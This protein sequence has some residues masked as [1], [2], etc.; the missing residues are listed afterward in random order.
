MN[1]SREQ[2]SQQSRHQLCIR[3]VKRKVVLSNKLRFIDFDPTSTHWLEEDSREDGTAERN[4]PKNG[5]NI[6]KRECGR[7]CSIVLKP[8]GLKP[9][10]S[11]VQRS[12][13]SYSSIFNDSYPFEESPFSKMAK[14]ARKDMGLEYLGLDKFH[15]PRARREDKGYCRCSGC[16]SSS[17]SPSLM[18]ISNMVNSP[19][20]GSLF[21]RQDALDVTPDQSLRLGI[22]P[23]SP[24]NKMPRCTLSLSTIHLPIR[25][26]SPETD[27]ESMSLSSSSSVGRN[28]EFPYS[29]LSDVGAPYKR[30][31]EKIFTSTPLSKMNLLRNK[32]EK[33]KSS[34]NPVDAAIHSGKITKS[35]S[36]NTSPASTSP[37]EVLE[38]DSS[39][40]ENPP[41]TF[42]SHAA[43]SAIFHLCRQSTDVNFS[44]YIAERSPV[45]LKKLGEGAFSEVFLCI[46]E[47]GKQ[48]IWKV[49]PFGGDLIF[50]GMAQRKSGDILS[51]IRLIRSLSDLRRGEKSMTDCFIEVLNF[52]VVHGPFPKLLLDCW[53]E[54]D[55]EKGSENDCPSMFPSTQ[56]FMI[57]EMEYAGVELENFVFASATQA[58]SV[59]NQVAF[60]LAVAEVALEFEHRDLHWGNIIV[61]K[62]PVEEITFILNEK[63]NILKTRGVI[64]KIVDFSL[65]RAT[66]EGDIYF[67]DLADIPEIF[68]STGEYQ[69]EIYRLMRKHKKYVGII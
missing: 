60:A 50:N 57:M 16:L 39:I 48:V 17:K 38:I 14:T 9:G 2:G 33:D 61:S 27:E 47:E 44:T 43:K 40:K 12:E 63:K 15:S 46:D 13:Y 22:V 34:V 42:N 3:K 62:T 30:S 10:T 64:A 8:Q 24:W 31:R 65:S 52:K 67:S 37:S 53:K 18:Q 23:V 20:F 56:R 69:F 29:I 1:K 36:K 35:T 11:K 21:N 28:S 5:R 25:S 54:Y 4:R 32:D 6:F 45:S 49:Q 68:E 55:D 59:F 41:A 51:E 7:K 19:P 66:I 26:S 58:L